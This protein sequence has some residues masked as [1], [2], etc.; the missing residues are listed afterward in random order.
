MVKGGKVRE[1][2]VYRSEDLNERRGPTMRK[3]VIAMLALALMLGGV[4][5]AA[6]AK[7]CYMIRDTSV[8]K[9]GDWFATLGKKG[10]E[11]NRI[12]A[13]RKHDRFI[14]CVEKN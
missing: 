2:P 13:K 6:Y 10:M 7:N 9:T 14:A 12:L 4:A 8:D 11:K 1:K 5:T 3:S